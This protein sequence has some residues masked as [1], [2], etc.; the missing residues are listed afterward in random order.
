MPSPE[1]IE[2]AK[3]IIRADAKHAPL[4]KAGGVLEGGFLVTHREAK[5]PHRMLQIQLLTKDHS[6]LQRLVV[7]DLVDRK[8]VDSVT[9][10]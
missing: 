8:I 1:E 9:P 7:V 2:E 5:G 3:A 4:L 6:A 10:K